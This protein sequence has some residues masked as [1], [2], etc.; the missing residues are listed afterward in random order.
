MKRVKYEHA[1]SQ[2]SQCLSGLQN[3]PAILPLTSLIEIAKNDFLAAEKLAN[4][5]LVNRRA[6]AVGG[7]SGT[8]LVS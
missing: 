4:M 7:S 6:D 8:G 3:P 1:N 5:L 2:L